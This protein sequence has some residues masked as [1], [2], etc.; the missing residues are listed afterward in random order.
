MRSGVVGLASDVWTRFETE[1]DHSWPT[2]LLV[3]G[4]ALLVGYYAAW[5]LAD[6]GPRTPL[7]GVG[8]ILAAI[9][10][11]RQP[12]RATVVSR[13]CYLLAGSTILIPFVFW[14]VYLTSPAGIIRP[15]ALILT[16]GDVLYAFA[17]VV[18]A[19]LIA[20]VGRFFGWWIAT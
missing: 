9:H 1:H 6:I 20:G 17:F 11:Y 10:L 19:G 2:R 16:P 7:F 14:V 8:T 4:C 5:V 3:A 12:T 13:A 15:F 18:L